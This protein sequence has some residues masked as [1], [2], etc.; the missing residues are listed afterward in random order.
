MSTEKVYLLVWKADSTHPGLIEHRVF[1]ESEIPDEHN[2]DEVVGDYREFVEAVPGTL[3]Y[4]LYVDRQVIDNPETPYETLKSITSSKYNWE[5]GSLDLTFLPPRTWDDIR[6]ERNNMLAASDNM[7]NEDTPDPLKSEWV[8]FRALLRDL[9]DREK[10]AGRTPDTVKWTDYVPPYPY[11]A[12]IGVPDDVKATCV[13]Y[14]GAD[15]F[16]PQAIIGS[17]ESIAAHEE[18]L[19][20]QNSLTRTK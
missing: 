14:K 19:K 4:R 2:I 18:F 7:F 12:R 20:I 16:P 3:F 6:F 1:K 13:W 8:E 9:I 5:T 17:P 11:S 10:A 15:T